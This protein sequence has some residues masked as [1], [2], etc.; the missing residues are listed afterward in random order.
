MKEEFSK[1]SSEDFKIILED[2]TLSQDG[3]QTK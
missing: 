2:K 3:Y 1:L